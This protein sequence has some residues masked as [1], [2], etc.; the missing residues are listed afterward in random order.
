[1]SKP[2][3]TNDNEL[4][5]TSKSVKM[6]QP[7]KLKRSE[8]DGLDISLWDEL[9]TAEAEGETLDKQYY[10]LTSDS[11]FSSQVT[12]LRMLK[13]HADTGISFE[14]K[15]SL[16]KKTTKSVWIW[17]GSVAVAAS[18]ALLLTLPLLKTDSSNHPVA[19]GTTQPKAGT[20]QPAN[21]TPPYSSKANNQSATV[22]TA[23][24]NGIS[25]KKHTTN[26]PKQADSKTNEQ[27]EKRRQTLGLPAM[28]PL[29]EPPV[30]LAGGSNSGIERITTTIPI[31]D[32]QLIA[33]NSTIGTQQLEQPG[34]FRRIAERG[35]VQFNSIFDQG[36]LVVKEYNNEGKLTLYA[37]QSNTFSFE[38][39][40]GQ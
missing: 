23:N 17:V 7:E 11:E 2:I 14:N 27:A 36:T 29:N 35:I 39:K 8:L 1:M 15:N 20:N 40:Y 10:H 19:Q 26:S 22:Q 24:S 18:L 16:K 37:V 5:L 38:K 4:R 13:L 12:Q 6:P 32:M 21:T 9:C 34:L 28:P 31:E 33:D 25:E 30:M 3:Y